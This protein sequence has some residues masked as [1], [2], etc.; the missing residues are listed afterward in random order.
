M[1]MLID[2][3]RDRKGYYSVEVLCHVLMNRGIEL[4]QLLPLQFSNM[5]DADVIPRVRYLHNE[6]RGV[7]YL[8]NE[9]SLSLSS[10]SVIVNIG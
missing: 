5:S 2:V 1:T 9:E 3:M 4:L 7:S 8:H 6:E 10:D